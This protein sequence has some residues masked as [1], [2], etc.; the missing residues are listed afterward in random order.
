M[1]ER[2]LQT[3]QQYPYYALVRGQAVQ[4]E[5]VP[6]TASE[7]A[8]DRLLKRLPKTVFKLKGSTAGLESGMYTPIIFETAVFS[9]ALLVPAAAV[10]RDPDLGRDFVYVLD[11]S[12]ERTRRDVE[13]LSD[14]VKAVILSGLSEGEVLYVYE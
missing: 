4:V 6:R 5:Y 3:L 11:E 13:I 7:A 12:G 14:G 8:S 2:M 10:I 1:E 9:D